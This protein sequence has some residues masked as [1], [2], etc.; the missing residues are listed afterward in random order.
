MTRATFGEGLAALR[1]AQKPARG[2]AAYSRHVNRPAGRIVAA[3]L[4]TV[5][6][7][8]NQVS[9]VSALF[10]FAGIALL[11][12]AEVTVPTGIAVAVLLAVGYVLDSVDGQLA[13]LSGSGSVSGEWLDHTIDCFKTTSLNLAVLIGWYRSGWTDDDA[14]LLV[15]IGFTIV[16][17]VTYF[18]L[19]L[20]PTLRPAAP[21]AE[22]AAEHPLRKYLLLPTDYGFQCWIFVLWGV[23]EV[24]AW[25]YAGVFAC[26]A[27]LLAVALRKW[28]RE[29]R[30][31][32]AEGRA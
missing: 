20:M 1:S 18:G 5:A 30:A 26:C 17:V 16:A 29:L 32:D 6:M 14:W 19:M 21:A 13:R 4:N 10:S 3:A 2:T 23:T 24:F 27:L 8:P 7:T 9:V 11:A 12:L 25:V 15:P 28:W 31:I 22:P